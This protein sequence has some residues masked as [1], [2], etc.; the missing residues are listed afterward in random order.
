MAP[1][2]AQAMTAEPDL[3]R[4]SGGDWLAASPSGAYFSMGVTAPTE[5]EA[6]EKFGYV[7]TR[8]LEIIHG[9]QDLM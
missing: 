1:F 3:I 2:P 8:W 4:R 6:R 5:A 7:F 9:S